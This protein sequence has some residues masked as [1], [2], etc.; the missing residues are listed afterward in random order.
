MD[1]YLPACHDK[2]SEIN[3]STFIS[4][5]QTNRYLPYQASSLPQLLNPAEPPLLH[6]TTAFSISWYTYHWWLSQR[7]WES[8]SHSLRRDHCLT[9]LPKPRGLSCAQGLGNHSPHDFQTKPDEVRR[10]AVSVMRTPI[11]TTHVLIPPINTFPF[12]LSW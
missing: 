8:I 10:V 12:T 6:I 11:P 3:I 7:A 5:P 4:H 2:S 9:L 1:W